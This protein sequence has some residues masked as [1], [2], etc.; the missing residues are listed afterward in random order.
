MRHREVVQ[1]AQVHTLKG[2]RTR[3]LTQFCLA[4]NLVTFTTTRHRDENKVKHSK[5]NLVISIY[6]MFPEKAIGL[7]LDYTFYCG[8]IVVVIFFCTIYHVL[9]AEDT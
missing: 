5:N 6:L 8:R 1:L 2:E 7:S 9:C 3:I 4:R